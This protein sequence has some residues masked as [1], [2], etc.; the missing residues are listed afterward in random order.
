MPALEIIQSSVCLACRQ[1]PGRID[2]A[3]TSVKKAFLILLLTMLVPFVLG[4]TLRAIPL[5]VYDGFESIPLS[6]LRWSRSR[7]EPGAVVSQVQLFRAGR[8]ALAIMAHRGDRYE[9]GIEGSVR[10]NAP[11]GWRR[12]G[13]SR[14]LAACMFIPSA[15]TFRKTSR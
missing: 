5:H 14:G 1:V 10:P 6:R 12:G 15:Y 8:R 4:A 2:A 3:R 7:F 13:G 9:Q 11:N